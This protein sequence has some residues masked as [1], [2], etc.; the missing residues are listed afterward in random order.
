MRISD[1]SSDV[2]SSDLKMNRSRSIPSRHDDRSS[3]DALNRT[4][5]G[6]EARIEGLMHTSGNDPQPK[7]ET[8]AAASKAPPSIDPREEIRERQRRLA[9]GRDRL[10]NRPAA[11]P[12]LTDAQFEQRPL[13]QAARPAPAR[14]G[15]PIYPAVTDHGDASLRGIAEAL[16][17]LR[18][19]LKQDIAESVARELGA[20]RS[21]LRGIRTAAESQHI[22]AD[23]SDDLARLAEGIDQMGRRGGPEAASLRSEYEEL[24]RVLD[25]LAREE[26]VERLDM[27][28]QR[29]ED[30]MSGIDTRELREELVGLAYRIDDI[31]SQLGTMSDSP[32]IR[33]LEQ[34]L[35]AVA[36]AMEQLG[37]RMHPN[38]SA[39]A[40]QFATLDDRLDEISRAIVASGRAS[41]AA[42]MDQGALQR[43]ENRLGQIGR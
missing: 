25:G 33:T 3:L 27:R 10:G 40:E 9:T 2:C 17:G 15:R 20:V 7:D 41:S 1:L 22:P 31:K 18:Q 4:I 6:L 36:G 35:L 38:D 29:M 24:R 8:E 42:S 12:H 23:L 34:K 14:T 43:L 11:R 5:E 26:S 16:V 21:D 39:L 28:W 19:E 30:Q 13:P 37:S 32:A